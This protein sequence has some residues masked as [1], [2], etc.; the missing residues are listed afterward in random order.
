MNSKGTILVDL[1]DTL[2]HTYKLNTIMRE[3]LTRA[4]VSQDLLEPTLKEFRAQNN[5]HVDL[6]KYVDFLKK[7]YGMDINEDVINDFYE[8]PLTELVKGDVRSAVS[9][10]QKLGFNVHLL[11]KGDEEF[12]IFKIKNA[13]LYE[14]FHPNIH[15]CVD[16]KDYIGNLNLEGPVI[17]VNDRLRE[18]KTI[19]D[20]FPHFQYF[21]V[22]RYDNHNLYEQGE[23]DMDT[24][25]TIEDLLKKLN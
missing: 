12:Q 3:H 8:L 9:D 22:N 20:A 6:R 11:S 1:D 2:I 4:G 24:I 16:K 21:H 19:R 5:T 7:N 15:I 13:G 17:I 18:T 25:D 10:L 23:I 14:I